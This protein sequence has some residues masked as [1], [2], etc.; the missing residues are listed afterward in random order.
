MKHHLNTL[1]VMTQGAYLKKDGEAVAVRIEKQIRLRVPLI[2]LSGIVCFGRIACSPPLLGAC[3]RAGV[4]AL[5]SPSTADCL[6][7][8]TDSLPVTSSCAVPSTAGR[9]IRNNQPV[10]PRPLFSANL[11]TIAL[12]FAELPGNKRILLSSMTFNKLANI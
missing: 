11:P 1:F 10:L 2:N 12:S 9:T 3:A 7:F 6:P 5:F 4:A 8:P